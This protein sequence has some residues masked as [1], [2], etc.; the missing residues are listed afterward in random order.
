[1]IVVR[2]F[3]PTICH[4]NQIEGSNRI[5]DPVRC[6]WVFA[7]ILHPAQKGVAVVGDAE[8]GKQKQIIPGFAGGSVCVHG[9]DATS[10]DIDRPF[11]EAIK[12]F[13]LEAAIA[14]VHDQIVGKRTFTWHEGD[15]ACP[16]DDLRNCSVDGF[17]VRFV[18][19]LDCPGAADFR[20]LP[21]VFPIF[22][23]SIIY[24]V[25]GN[26]KSVAL[27]FY[28]SYLMDLRLVLEQD[29][30]KLIPGKFQIVR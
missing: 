10:P 11:F 28:P 19:Y 17:S 16:G 4:M 18:E 8:T 1:M 14:A 3:D 30:N 22:K 2:H 21:S 29:I 12:P 6:K 26:I 20:W 25:S 24:T 13:G 27:F 5:P 15:G 9:Y 7:G 23:L